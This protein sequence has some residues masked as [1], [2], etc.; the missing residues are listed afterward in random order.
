MIVG[1]QYHQQ[2]GMKDSI[3]LIMEDHLEGRHDMDGKHIILMQLS[4]C[5]EV[6]FVHRV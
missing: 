1:A 3:P 2:H 6:L 4:L 5:Y